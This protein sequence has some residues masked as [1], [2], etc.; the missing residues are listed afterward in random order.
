MKT[1]INTVNLDNCPACFRREASFR[2]IRP[3]HFHFTFMK[4]KWANRTGN[5]LGYG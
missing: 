4:F 2:A 5:A 1:T 3:N